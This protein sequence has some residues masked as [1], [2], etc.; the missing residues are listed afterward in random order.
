MVNSMDLLVQMRSWL[1]Q[2]LNIFYKLITDDNSCIN[3]A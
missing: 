1:E 3:A 2:I